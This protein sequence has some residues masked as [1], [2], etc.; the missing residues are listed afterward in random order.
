MRGDY[1]QK[2]A[3]EAARRRLDHPGS[4]QSRERAQTTTRF[5]AEE[6]GNADVV[7]STT[8]L[9]LAFLKRICR[10]QRHW[11]GAA[12]TK[13]LRLEEFVKTD[14]F[15]TMER[16]RALVAEAIGENSDTD[17]PPPGRRMGHRVFGYKTYEFVTEVALFKVWKK[18]A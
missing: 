4:A 7:G 17:P 13:R 1:G 15:L 5:Y 3:R 14:E 16:A 10:V 18:V 8:V 9:D 2:E 11:K 12:M 6:N